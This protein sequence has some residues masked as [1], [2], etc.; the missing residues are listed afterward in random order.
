MIPDDELQG[1]LRKAVDQVR[2]DPASEDLVDRCAARAA[3]I[4]GLEAVRPMFADLGRVGTQEAP[5]SWHWP[6]TICL[7]ASLLITLSLNALQIALYRPD[8]HRQ[9][10]AQ[11]Q[12]A[13]QQNYLIY[14]DLRLERVFSISVPH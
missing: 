11:I 1:A 6:A 5:N 13:D 9:Q 3:E 4:P 8:P 7:A 10:A 2:Q 12:T 14:S